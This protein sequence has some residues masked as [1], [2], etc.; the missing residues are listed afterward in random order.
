MPGNVYP[1][2]EVREHGQV[3]AGDQHNHIENHG[4]LCTSEH[5]MNE[6]SLTLAQS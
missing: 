6:R 5:R 2:I 1:S 3:L 4:Q